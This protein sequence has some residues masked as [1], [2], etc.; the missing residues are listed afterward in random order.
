MIKI[1]EICESMKELLDSQKTKGVVKVY[2]VCLRKNENLYVN[3]LLANGQTE[4]AGLTES[5]LQLY[6]D[7]EIEYLTD[8]QLEETFYKAI[9]NQKANII[10]DSGHRRNGNLSVKKAKAKKTES[11]I[12]VSFYSY[13]GGMGRTTA[14]AAYALY[15][16][17]VCRMKVVAIDCD[18]EA[19][20]LNNFFLK[21]PAEQNNHNGL[22]EYLLDKSTGLTEANVVTDY[23]QEVDHSISGEG[24]IFMMPAGNMGAER[25]ADGKQMTHM[26][27]YLEGISRIDINNTCYANKVFEALI[28]DIDSAIHPDVIL[29]DSKT[30]I[31]DVMGLAVCS[32]ADV[33]VGFFRNDV[34]TLPGLRFFV[35]TMMDNNQVEPYLVNSILPS[36]ASQ[37][38]M[39]FNQFA[40]DVECIIND[41]DSDSNISFPCYPIGR[42]PDFEVLGSVAEQVEN[43]VESVR[44][45][46]FREYAELFGDLTKSIQ[47]RKNGVAGGETQ[48]KEALREAILESTAETLNSIDLYAENQ[49]IV[50]DIRNR[51]FYYRRCMNDLLNH[52]KYLVIGSKGTGKSYIYNALKEPQVVDMVKKN[53]GKTGDFKFV[54]AIDRNRN[55]IF[56]VAKLGELDAAG[57]YK[58][59]LIYTWNIIVSDIRSMFPDFEFTEDANHIDITDT[60]TSREQLSQLITND[61]YIQTV[62]MELTRLD[63]Y[64][65]MRQEQTYLDIIFDQLDDMVSPS[66]WNN[67]IPELIKYWRVGRFSR[68]GAKLFIRRDLFKG[69]VGLTNINDIENQAIDIEWRKEEIYSYFFYVVLND[70]IR[71]KFWRLMELYGNYTHEQVLEFSKEY[72]NITVPI[73]KA[74]MLE[75]LMGTFFGET[76]DVEGTTRMGKSYDWFYKNLKNADDTISLRPF[77]S[78]LK[79]AVKK[80]I[81]DGMTRDGKNYPVLYQSCYINS[82]VRKEAVKDHLEDLIRNAKGNLPIQYVFEYVSSSEK[83]KYHRISLRRP[84]FEELLQAVITKNSDKEG[85]EGISVEQLT[86]ILVDNGI[87][88][89]TNRGSGDLYSFSFLYKYRLGLHGS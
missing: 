83:P 87:V 77:I 22:V 43:F 70:H 42:Q 66:I 76:V 2:R 5:I 12:V 31:N 29:V 74:K 27:H 50:E 18:Y 68:I 41:I 48:E 25:I 65:V 21:Y 80:Q 51:H 1:L 73:Y 10:L 47:R 20:G 85:M 59:W 61:G 49:A 72:D 81:N 6:G 53:A 16:S 9:F 63:Q 17:A 4:N 38:R 78:L 36:A 3:V 56:D 52:D 75:A 58:F 35:K 55:R 32:L 60:I 14:L 88:A 34:Q 39:L 40:K 79:L 46:D 37:R 67:W 7:A 86:T 33:V 13:K 26:D 64:L 54:Y 84:V 82:A 57:K 89:K 19:P 8:E 69:L 62:E 23:M 44:N 45:G 71:D 24:T 28:S 15:L 11:P 30:G